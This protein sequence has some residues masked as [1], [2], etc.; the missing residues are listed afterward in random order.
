MR[1]EIEQ[2]EADELTE[3]QRKLLE[4][5][6]KLLEDCWKQDPAERLEMTEVVQRI[7]EMRPDLVNT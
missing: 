6:W 4:D 5:C 7:E 3:Q 1:P 2:Y